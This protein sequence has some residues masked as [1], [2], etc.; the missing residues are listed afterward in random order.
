MAWTNADR[1]KQAALDAKI[2]AL[3]LKLEESNQ[4]HVR[5]GLRIK[6]L[7]ALM[8]KLVAALNRLTN[9]GA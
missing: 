1:I 4:V 2:D 8:H 6:S 3:M 5:E 7:T 9:G